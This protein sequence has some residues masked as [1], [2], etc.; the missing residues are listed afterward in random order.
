MKRLGGIIVVALCVS[1]CKEQTAPARTPA[2]L[3]HPVSIRAEHMYSTSLWSLFAAQG[4]HSGMVGY[5]ADEKTPDLGVTMDGTVEQVLKA[6]VEK[7]PRYSWEVEGAQTIAIKLRD[8]SANGLCSE[9]IAHFAVTNV[10]LY[11]AKQALAA[12]STFPVKLLITPGEMET[13]NE[14]VSVDLTGATFC[15]VVERLAAAYPR[16]VSW[17]VTRVGDYYRFDLQV[18]SASTH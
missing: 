6:F 12:T 9:R 10:P 13:L 8:P 3:A 14:R 2:V 18:V 7:H 16:P 15:E 11:E 5:L 17:A 4:V 1:A